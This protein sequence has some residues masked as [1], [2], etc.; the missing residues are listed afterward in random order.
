[1]IADKPPRL[2]ATDVDGTLLDD[3]D[4][5][6]P[7][8]AAVLSRL[9]DAGTGF[10]L[11]TGRPPRWI[12]PVV[13][14]LPPGMVRLCVCANGA[15]LY[16][17]VDDVLLGARTL[18]PDAVRR[19][20]AL[21]GKLFPGCGLGVERV[22]NS[23]TS[24]VELGTVDEFL[25]GP[26]YVHA[27]GDHDGGPVSPDELLARP[28]TKLLIRAPE[29]TSEQMMTTLEPEIGG[30]ADL[31]FSHPSGLLEASAPGVTKATGLADVAARLGVTAAETIAFGDMP[32][33]REMLRW[34]GIGVAMGNAH[35]DLVGL[36]DEVT[37]P[38]SRDGIAEVLERWF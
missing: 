1:M 38:N 11:V 35:P 22:G 32:N 21:A 20:A 5:V 18:E 14:K 27:W 3:R 17:A 9:V 28:V 6:S 31:T 34:A 10:V 7:R 2:V 25:T 36:A 29:L 30:I 15:V 16:D 23:A 13:A 37:A 26:G 8:T 4:D 24:R 12:P 33:D 19:L